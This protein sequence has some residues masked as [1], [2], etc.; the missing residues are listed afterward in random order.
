MYQPSA[1]EID[2]VSALRA[3]ERYQ[4]LIKRIADAERVWSLRNSSGWVLAA[5]DAGNVLVPIWPHEAFAARCATSQWSDCVPQP[6][7]LGEWRDR[8]LPGIER[9]GRTIAAF[10]TPDAQGVAVEPARLRQDLT[11][12]LLRYD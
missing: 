3:E 4:Y 5:D 2:A 10:P 7:D 1:S 6:I 12:E 8:W 11:A 9:D